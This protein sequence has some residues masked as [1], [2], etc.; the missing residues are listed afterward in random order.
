LKENLSLPGIDDHAIAAFRRFYTMLPRND[1]PVLVILKLHLL[2]E[3]QVRAFIDE[4]LHNG[5]ALKPAKLECHQVICLAEALSKEDIHPSLWE[6][7]R[8]LTELRNKVA[9]II[10]PAGVRER[11]GNICALIGL[12]PEQFAPPP[13]TDPSLA[14]LDHFSFAV[15]MLHNELPMFVKR[16]PAALLQL[17]PAAARVVNE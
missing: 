14:M 16:K 5:L 2:V 11:I 17:G 15:S 10:E 3:E 4:R 13:G 6:A 9:H 7:A 1:D 8:K 12:R